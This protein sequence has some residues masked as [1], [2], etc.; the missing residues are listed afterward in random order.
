ME[1]LVTTNSAVTFEN[2]EFLLRV[3]EVLENIVID[4]GSN[5]QV[6]IDI[7]D[8]EIINS[9]LFSDITT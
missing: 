8:C 2:K 7:K 4:G 9:N 3:V 1:F 6:T 5:S